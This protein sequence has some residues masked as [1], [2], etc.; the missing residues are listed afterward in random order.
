VVLGEGRRDDAHK[1][2]HAHFCVAILSLAFASA[3][4]RLEAFCEGS[5]RKNRDKRG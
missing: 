3:V 2:E 4:R 5:L 1:R